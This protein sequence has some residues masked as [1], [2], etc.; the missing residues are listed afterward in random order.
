[1]S[2]A[3]GEAEAS[4][5]EIFGRPCGHACRIYCRNALVWLVTLGCIGFYVVLTYSTRVPNYSTLSG[6]LVTC[7]VRASLAPNCSAAGYYDRL[8]LRPEHMTYSPT[9]KHLPECKWTDKPKW[10]SA[11]FEPEGVLSTVN[12]M[13]SSF[14]VATRL[15]LI[16]GIFNGE[17][18][19][20]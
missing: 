2:T 6:E 15:I 5:V 4:C 18:D 10:C 1:M 12:G 19:C 3:T 8:I 14:F 7:G 13:C 20:E 16:V 17:V 9:F 11:Q